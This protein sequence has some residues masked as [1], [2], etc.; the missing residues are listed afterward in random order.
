MADDA[1]R[2][3]EQNNAAAQAIFQLFQNWLTRV[4]SK[5]DN[6]TGRL[7]GKADRAEVAEISARL[8]SKVDRTEFERLTSK[9]DREAERINQR[10]ETESERIDALDRH[11]GIGDQ[12]DTERKEWRQWVI[13][14]IMSA[15]L[16]GATVFMALK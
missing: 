16:A 11:V 1:N 8:D 6:L 4:E 7:E 3:A 10:V 5:I 14:L 13:P 2:Q 12:R 15:I 9:L